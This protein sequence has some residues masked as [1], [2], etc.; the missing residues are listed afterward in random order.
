MLYMSKHPEWCRKPGRSDP[1]TRLL[2]STVRSRHECPRIKTLNT[3]ALRLPRNGM[4]GRPFQTC[5][6]PE[7][8]SLQVGHLIGEADFLAV[9]L[10]VA[11]AAIGVWR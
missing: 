5:L 8:N 9:A 3:D 10:V 7:P 6:T 4:S 1:V 2:L 11:I